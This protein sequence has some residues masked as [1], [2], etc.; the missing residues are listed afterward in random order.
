MAIPL[1]PM[2]G[3][4]AGAA[5]GTIGSGD[6]LTNFMRT[7]FGGVPSRDASNAAELEAA[8]QAGNELGLFPD[9]LMPLN[10]G[11]F[12]PIPYGEKLQKNFGQLSGIGRK[13]F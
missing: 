13:L 6:F 7:K 1:A 2:L 12:E 5:G 3:A 10:Q 4:A 9:A 11:L 8:R